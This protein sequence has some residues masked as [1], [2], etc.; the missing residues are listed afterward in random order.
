MDR[1]KGEKEGEIKE[2]M[3]LKRN[4]KKDVKSKKERCIFCQKH[5]SS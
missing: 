1:Q 4:S 2:K 5:S 3:E